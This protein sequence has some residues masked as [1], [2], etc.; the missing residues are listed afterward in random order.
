[1]ELV[2]ELEALKKRMEAMPSDGKP[3]QVVSYLVRETL[4][5][6]MRGVETADFER[7]HFV[8]G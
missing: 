2:N 8:L 7:Q 1:M 6:L 5:A 3:W 4:A